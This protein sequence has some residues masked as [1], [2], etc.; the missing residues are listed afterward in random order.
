[1]IAPQR[2]DDALEAH[3]HL[4]FVDLDTSRP[5]PILVEALLGSA[6]A[7]TQVVETLG[8]AAHLVTLLATNLDQLGVTRLDHVSMTVDQRREV[9]DGVQ[10]LL[11]LAPSLPGVCSCL[12]I[13]LEATLGLEQPP[14]EELLAFVQPGV[15]HVDVLAPIGKCG[16]PRVEP[17]PGLAARLRCLGLGGLVCFELWDQRLQLGDATAF[18]AQPVDGIGERVLQGLQFRL[19]V[20]ALGLR[21]GQGIGAGG[22]PGVV[23]IELAAQLCLATAC[24]LQRA[25]RCLLCAATTFELCGRDAETFL[26]LL[27]G[28]G[29][30]PSPSGPD[31]PTR[32]AEPVAIVGDD[33]GERVVDRDVDRLG[34]RRHARRRSEDGIEQLGNAGLLTVHVRPN[35]RPK[36]QRRR[37]WAM[38]S[39]ERDDRTVDVRGVKRI[40]GA[41]AGLRRGNDDRVQG[42]AEG[43]LDGGLPAGVDVDEVEQRAEH[44]F[45]AGEVFGPGPS[46][47]TFQGQVERLGACTPT[48]HVVGRGLASRSCR[49]CRGL[50]GDPLRFGGFDIG[51]QSR[52]DDLRLPAFET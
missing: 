25:G 45:H 29:R 15:A 28:R 10:I 43:G 24:T 44:A 14:L 32:R 23:G 35:R 51:D 1:M 37:R 30:G 18:A 38:S 17:G 46:P 31:P 50:G 33:H 26:G 9:L 2:L 42:F 52:L 5:L 7:S 34:P 11:D 16:G 20:T 40:E 6:A 21:S 49:G 22:E 4:G 8:D 48:R 12:G 39:T 47:G 27:Q 19:A 3:A 41:T 13:D 36:P